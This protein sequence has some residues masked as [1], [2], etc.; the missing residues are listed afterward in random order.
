[1]ALWRLLSLNV[2]I[3]VFYAEI[4]TRHVALAARS[5]VIL[6]RCHELETDNGEDFW[7]SFSR[8]GHR[9]YVCVVYIKPSARDCDYMEWFCK[10]EHTITVLKA[11]V[12]ILGVAAADAFANVF[13]STFLPDVPV[14]DTDEAYGFDRTYDSNYVNIFHITPDDVIGGINKL[15]QSSS[16]KRLDMSRRRL[17]I[18]KGDNTNTP[19]RNI[20]SQP[21]NI[22]PS[23]SGS[24]QSNITMRNLSRQGTSVIN[25]TSEFQS[26][27]IELTLR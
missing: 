9:F 21:S 3:G 4:E 26:E 11:P 1:M 19:I 5:P 25:Q 24:D 20:V 16:Q 27:Y 18:P 14:L 13:S 8:H 23:S 12:L 6:S 17:K 7:A 22:S 15:K 10:V 2:Q